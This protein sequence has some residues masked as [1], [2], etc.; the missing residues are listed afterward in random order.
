MKVAMERPY[1]VQ[2]VTNLEDARGNSLNE[3]VALDDELVKIDGHD[4]QGDGFCELEGLILGDCKT[5]VKLSFR[6]PG[7]AAPF[8]VEVASAP[9]R[10]PGPRNAPRALH[11]LRS[12]R[13]AGAGRRG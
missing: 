8:T 11:A 13:R 5:T 6:R 4:L 12:A 9:S 2:R 1:V 10:R 7:V 3:R